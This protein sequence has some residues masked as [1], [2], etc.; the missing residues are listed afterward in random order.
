WLFTD[1]VAGLA[2]SALRV[3]P[4]LAE[5]AATIRRH[6]E[7]MVEHFGGQT[8]A[9]RELRKHMAW[10]LKGYVV[11]GDARRALGLVST[12]AELDERLAALDLSQPYP[13]EGAEGPRGRA[14]SPKVPHL[15]EAWLATQDIDE[16]L[17][18]LLEE[19][20]LAISGG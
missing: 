9:L 7:L 20:E 8:K 14:G 17:R 11:G 10:Y 4:G 19:A 3:R 18:R 6:A 12:L 2:G 13:G 5:V 15:P 1:L 16:P